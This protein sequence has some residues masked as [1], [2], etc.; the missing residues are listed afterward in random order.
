VD[1]ADEHTKSIIENALKKSFAPEFLNRI[2][3]VI[4]FNSLSKE[5]I[6]EIIDIELEKLLGRIKDL[7]YTLNLTKTAKDFVADKGF[8]QKFGAR[9]LAR[10]IQKYIEDPLAEEIINSNVEE[11]DTIKL[12]YKKND[13]ELTIDIVKKG[14]G[15]EKKSPPKKI[16]E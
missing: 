13:K 8:D 1:G 4:L 11:G 12:S 2:D 10:A 15:N 5:N 3:D 6:F 16:Q 14:S 9:P 7:G